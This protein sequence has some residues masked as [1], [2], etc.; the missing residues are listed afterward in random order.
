DMAFIWSR[1]ANSEPAGLGDF[2]ALAAA[3]RYLRSD[4]FCARVSDMCGDGARRQCG[5][6]ILT[7]SYWGSNIIPHIDSSNASHNVNMIFFIDGT[8]GLY[9]GGLG[10]WNDNEFQDPIFIPENL[11]NTCL[12]YD[13]S[14]GFFHGFPPMKFG[15]FRWTINATYVGAA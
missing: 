1:A 12:M 6:I 2:P 13:M 14:E 15:S 9:G 4:E 7:R 5:Q 8:G 11:R 3:Y 10:I